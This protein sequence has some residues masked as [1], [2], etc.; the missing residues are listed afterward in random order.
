[1]FS[2]DEYLIPLL[3]RINKGENICLL[4]KDFN[5][6]S[7]NSDTNPDIPEFFENFCSHFFAPYI[8]QQTF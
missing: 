1:M 4:M 7:L 5:I 8:L 6:N 2:N 3:S